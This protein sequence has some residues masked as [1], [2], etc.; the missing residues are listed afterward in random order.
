MI[1]NGG[2]AV[3]HTDPA[4]WCVFVKASSIQSLSDRFYL[5]VS[6]Q[7]RKHHHCALIQSSCEKQETAFYLAFHGECIGP[8]FGT[9]YNHVFERI[10]KSGKEV[11][12]EKSIIL[13]RYVSF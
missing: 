12:N 10:H 11:R 13:P 9:F 4:C 1:N 7:Q 6:L 5:Y 8:V 2:C 3:N